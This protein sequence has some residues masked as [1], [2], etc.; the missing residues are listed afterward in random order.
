M[1]QV[2]VQY[3]EFVS[4]IRQTISNADV[5]LLIKIMYLERKLPDASPKVDLHLEYGLDVDPLKKQE[6]IRAKYGFPTQMSEHGLTAVGRMN[7]ALIEEISKDPDIEHI[8]GRAT[9]ASY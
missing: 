8:S 5:D 1:S 3:E 9:P 4:K 6:M 7:I 2:E